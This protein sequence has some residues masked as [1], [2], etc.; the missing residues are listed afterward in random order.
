MEQNSPSGA[1]TA[2]P[3][4]RTQLI[5][6]SRFACTAT[7]AIGVTVLLAAIAFLEYVFTVYSAVGEFGV[8]W[9]IVNEPPPTSVKRV[10]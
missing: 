6:L 5:L 1:L 2:D 9:A 7:G 10:Y 8:F 4:F 3:R